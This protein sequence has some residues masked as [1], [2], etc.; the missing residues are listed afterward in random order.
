MSSVVCYGALKDCYAITWS[1]GEICV[2]CNCCGRINSD[3][4]KILKAKLR[5]A[6]EQLSE[7]LHFKN[8][9]NTPEIIRLQEYNLKENKRYWRKEVFS[10]KNQLKTFN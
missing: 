9:G 10:I 5:Y 6:K 4:N 3:K 8:W 2:G 1:Y 7:Q